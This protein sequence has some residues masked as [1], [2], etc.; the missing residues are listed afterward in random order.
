M[1]QIF[2]GS[3]LPFASAIGPR[4]IRAMDA[5]RQTTIIAVC[6]QNVRHRRRNYRRPHGR[7]SP[8][9]I[10][11][12]R[13]GALTGSLASRRTALSTPSIY[14]FGTLSIITLV[15]LRVCIGWHFLYE[16]VW[17]Y[18]NPRFSSVGFLSQAKGPFAKFYRRVIPDLYGF[19]ETLAAED[20]A[21][22]VSL[23]IWRQH[24]I[25]QMEADV[26]RL[27][28]YSELSDEKIAAVQKQHSKRSDEL[29]ELAAQH[30]TA[31][32]K[33]F[34]EKKKL[35][36]ELKT[37][38]AE[39][40]TG[41]IKRLN[42]DLDDL[43]SAAKTWRGEAAKIRQALAKELSAATKAAAARRGKA[44]SA[45]PYDA[46]AHNIIVAWDDYGDQ[47]IEH[48]GYSDEKQTKARQIVSDHKAALWD[49]LAESRGD[50]ND[51]RVELTRLRRDVAERGDATFQK[52]RNLDKKNEL[53]GSAVGWR[54]W[55]RKQE[56]NLGRQLWALGDSD[57]RDKGQLAKEKSDLEVFDKVLIY[58]LIAIGGCLM[59]GLLTRL[60]SLGGAFFLLSVVLATPALPGIFPPDP[61]PGHSLF[62]T[63]EMIEMFAL[64]FL[65]TVPAGRWAGVDFFI[66][67]CITGRCCSSKKL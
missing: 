29:T 23:R 57:Q 24:Q 46:W 1:A 51:Y 58:S 31:I 17:K 18:T 53:N 44:P 9:V 40:K 34:P 25:G 15:I 16:G 65:V 48:Y 56:T 52:Q 37:A 2:F 47:A 45:A 3:P 28:D 60:A 22:P 6:S 64:L 36:G 33:Y 39:E 30:K 49:F 5:G 61:G 59:I 38:Q 21:G 14:K 55:V 63:K 4:F 10:Q 12:R 8:G 67:S 11:P 50:I 7:R 42:S 26:T 54:G 13:F 41:D 62:V 32:E 66:H 20:A 27:S 19:D 43:E 35:R